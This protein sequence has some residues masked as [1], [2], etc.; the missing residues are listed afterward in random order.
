MYET[1]RYVFHIHFEFIITKVQE[2]QSDTELH[3]AHALLVHAAGTCR[4][5]NICH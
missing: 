1:R 2:N 5:H 3:G 4:V